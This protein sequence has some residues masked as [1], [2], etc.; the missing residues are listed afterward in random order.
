M[1]AA[2]ILNFCT[3]NFGGK[4]DCGPPPSWILLD[5]SSEGKSCPGT[6]FSVS[7][8]NVVQIRSKIA[9]LWPFNWFQNGGRRYLE[10][11]SR[12]RGP[13][14]KSTSRPEHCV[15]ISCQSHYYCR[16]YG[17]LNI[18]QIWL[19]TPIPAPKIYVLGV[20]PLN[21]IFRHLYHQ[22]ALPWRKPRH[23]SH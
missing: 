18:W 23:M 13:P 1:A 5:K 16:R 3:V 9:K 7:V 14:A 6:L 4:S 17:H 19:R 8:S 21:I 10:L 2:A 12:N 20:L 15:K 22:K 11:L